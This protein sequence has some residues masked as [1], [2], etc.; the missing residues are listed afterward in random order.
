MKKQNR[1]KLTG[2]LTA[3]PA[4]TFLLVFTVYPVF[5]LIYASFFNGSLIQ[6]KRKFIGLGNYIYLFKSEDFQIVLRNTIIYTILLVMIVIVL[7]ILVAVWLNGKKH[8]RLNNFVQSITFMPHIISLVSVSLVFLWLMDADSGLLNMMFNILGLNPYPF[9]T[10]PQTAL[11]SLVIVMIWK[12]LGYYT[13]LI[14]AALQTIPSNI[15]EAAAVDDISPIRVFFKITLPMISPTILL[16]T[17]VATIN[18]F[19][20]FDTINIMT[21]GGPINSSNTLV[22]YIYQYAFKYSKIGQASA[23]G[24]ILLIL[25]S[26]LTIIQ[27]GVSKNK[28]QY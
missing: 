13:L 25:V 18:S 23:A 2:Y 19:K 6:T 10:S 17:V 8:S 11:F 20:V 21:Q 7:A 4:I 28:V 5:Y 3:M 24:V 22:Y 15:Y 27:F 14:M 12:S 9:L 16:T 26:V 1:E